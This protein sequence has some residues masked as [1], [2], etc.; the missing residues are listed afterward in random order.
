MDVP[1]AIL[2]INA[3]IG[4]SQT[5]NTYSFSSLLDA[6]MD[7]TVSNMFTSQ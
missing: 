5:D 6:V 1:V 4:D 3:I 2:D 7:S